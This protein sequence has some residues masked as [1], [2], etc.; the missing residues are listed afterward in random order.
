MNDRNTDRAAAVAGRFYSSDPDTLRN[1]IANLFQQADK[2]SDTEISVDDEIKALI[3]PHAGYVFSGVVAASAYKFLHSI[4]NIETIFILGSSHH[5]S[6]HGASVYHRGNYHTPFGVIEVDKKIAKKLLENKSMFQFF[7]EI[8]TPEH[9]IE[10]QLPFIQYI[11]GNTVKIV[12]II[13]GT[14][15]GEV[16]NEIAESLYPYFNSKNLFIIS[17][18]FSHYPEFNDAVKVD[19]NTTIEV[20]RNN[21]ETFQAYIH[22][23]KSKYISNLT[24]LMC[25]WTSV[26]TLLF[27][28]KGNKSICYKPLLYQNSGEIPIYGEKSKVVGYQSFAILKKQE[29][30]NVQKMKK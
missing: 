24:T 11:Y 15:S 2:L 20:C 18:D 17:T 1:D 22:H 5:A 4:K 14:K 19:R 29:K 30:Q 8:H 26:L 9:T 28:T 6:F 27:L 3:V 23:N 10:V 7:P 12:P 25:G 13:I 21:P 16:C